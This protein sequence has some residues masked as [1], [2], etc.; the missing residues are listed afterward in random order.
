[1]VSDLEYNEVWCLTDMYQDLRDLC[2]MD[3][4]LIE[5]DAPYMVPIM[6]MDPT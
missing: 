5:T 4:L 3:R 2:P 1:M 6:Y